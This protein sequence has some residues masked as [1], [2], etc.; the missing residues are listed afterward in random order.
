MTKQRAWSPK[1]PD[2]SVRICVT[3][4]EKG[5]SVLAVDNLLTGP[6]STIAHQRER[7]GAD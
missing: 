5:Y 3:P 6:E 7:V 2:F 1:A 4:V